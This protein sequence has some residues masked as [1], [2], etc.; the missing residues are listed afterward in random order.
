VDGRL[1]EMLAQPECRGACLPPQRW[2]D[3]T[4]TRWLLLDKVYDRVHAD[5][6]YDT[7]L[8]VELAAG[9]SSAWANV[10]AFEGDE[11]HA[12]YAC[13]ADGCAAPQSLDDALELVADGDPIIIDGLALARYRRDEAAAPESFGLRAV[14]P[15]T[16]HALTWVDRRTGDFVQLAPPGWQRVYS[17]DVKIY[18][19]LSAMPRAFVVHAAQTHSGDDES[20]LAMMGDPSFDPRQTVLLHSDRGAPTVS[21]AVGDSAAH[22]VAYEATR[23]VVRVEADVPGWLVLTDAYYPGWQATV[24]GEPVPLYRANLMFRAVPV[25]AGTHEIVFTFGY[26]SR[27]TLLLAGSGLLA[28]ALLAVAAWSA[29]HSRPRAA[30]GHST[31]T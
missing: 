15:L 24:D 4:G 14:D 27:L 19:N 12:L 2:L 30:T 9:E 28:L 22:I 11:L 29:Y 25:P 23:V 17:A 13:A 10:Q 20:A 26:G 5:I 18:E 1:R 21:E 7:G 6:F 16:L 31:S 3:L 8:P